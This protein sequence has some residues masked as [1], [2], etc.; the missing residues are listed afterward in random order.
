MTTTARPDLLEAVS[1]VAPVIREHAAAA[2]AERRIPTA[3]YGAMNDAGLFSMIAPAAYGGL[4]VHPREALI[5][6]EAVARIDVA[7]GWNLMMN[8]AAA[9]FAAW[10]PAEG[11]AELFA[12]GPTTVAGALNPPAAAVRADGGWRIS[13]QTP[14][15]SGCHNARW[16]VMPA[17]EMDGAV[18]KVNP[19]TGEPAPMA[20]FFPRDEAQILDTWNTVGMR[21]TGSADV[22]VHDLFVPDRRT[23]LVGPLHTPAPG[24]EGPLYRLFPWTAVLGESICSVGVAAQAVEDLV[25][26]VQTKVPAYNAVALR[27]QPLAQ[28]G[29]A[30]AK[31]R[32]DAA[33]DTLHRAAEDAFDQIAGGDLLTTDSKIRLQLA[34]SFAADICVEAVRA[35]S[36]VAGTSSVRTTQPF[37][38]YVRDIHTLSQHA[39]KANPRY[40]SA[41]RLMFGLP[42]DWIFHTF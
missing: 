16:L 39:S 35:V 5:V 2:E 17:V 31:A 18:P 6:W 19:E 14:F 13:G 21:G 33:R 37:E 20:V 23:M 36:D 4:E 41:G 25:T 26:L 24:F 34:C 42:V 15:A 38:K 27:D 7:H 22:A 8:Q 3:S 30:R 29:A 1:R 9:A 11:A 40:A 28:Y 10:L 12:D 32:V